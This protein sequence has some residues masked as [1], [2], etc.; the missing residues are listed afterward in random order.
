[1]LL[2]FESYC[3]LNSE[4]I[5]KDEPISTTATK[6]VHLQKIAQVFS[7]V[8]E[9]KFRENRLWSESSFKSFLFIFKLFDFDF[10]LDFF[11]FVCLFSFSCFSLI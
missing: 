11:L 8:V 5:S 3:D 10:D 1:M 9:D 4:Y 2:I 6:T 7:A